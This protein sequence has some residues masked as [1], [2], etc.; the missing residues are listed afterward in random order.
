M[1][2]ASLLC[3]HSLCVSSFL[4]LEDQ[5]ACCCAGGDLAVLSCA[6]VPYD[7]EAVTLS[8][9]RICSNSGERGARRYSRHVHS[10]GRIAACS[11][12]NGCF[13]QWIAA[14]LRTNIP[15]PEKATRCAIFAESCAPFQE[16]RVPSAACAQKPAEM[17]R[18]IQR[19]SVCTQACS[20]LSQ[21]SNIFP[22]DVFIP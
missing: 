5:G 16:V 6:F 11:H 18:I 1:F 12:G 19:Q 22:C 8:N 14:F 15:S 10:R 9:T 20:W 2:P 21:A 3:L 7:S 17:S 4:L 13:L